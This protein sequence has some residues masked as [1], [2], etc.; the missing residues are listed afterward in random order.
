MPGEDG[1]GGWGR[2]GVGVRGGGACA[3]G[4]EGE[5]ADEGVGCGLESLGGYEC[6]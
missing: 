5:E 1:E 3:T 6:G 2:V 4:L